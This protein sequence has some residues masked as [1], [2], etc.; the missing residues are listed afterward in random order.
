M[1][2]LKYAYIHILTHIF[3]CTF[4]NT[5]N[6]E[7]KRTSYIRKMTLVK[8]LQLTLYVTVKEWKKPGFVLLH[9]VNIL[10]EVL[11]KAFE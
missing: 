9:L 1:R 4:T 2:I 8:N 3:T 6:E 10:L 11:I 7:E 5:I